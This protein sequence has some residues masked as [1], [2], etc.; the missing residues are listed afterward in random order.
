[1]KTQN[2]NRSWLRLMLMV[3]TALFSMS[4]IAQKD[5]V[6]DNVEQMPQFPGGDVELMQYIAKNIKYPQKASEKVF[7]DVS[8]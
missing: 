1:M 6:Y 2:T 5:K 3:V 4:A 8:W 7:K